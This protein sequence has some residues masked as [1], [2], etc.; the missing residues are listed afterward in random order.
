MSTT[1]PPLDPIAPTDSPNGVSEYPTFQPP[2]G[3]DRVLRSSDEHDFRVH[4]VL[5]VMVS[6]VFRKM[7][8]SEDMRG[9]VIKL[10]EDKE[11]LSILFQYIY[12]GGCP[13]LDNLTQIKKGLAAAGA[14]EVTGLTK[15]LDQQLRRCMKANPIAFE[16]L[17][18]WHLSITLGLKETQEAAARLVTVARHDFRRPQVLAELA[19]EHPEA[20]PLIQLVGSQGVRAK[21][22]ADILFVFNA[23]PMLFRRDTHPYTVFLM[24]PSCTRKIVT[25][26]SNIVPAWMIQWAHTTYTFLLSNPIEASDHLFEPGN[27]WNQAASYRCCI[28]VFMTDPTYRSYFIAWA[29]GVRSKLALQLREAE[30][31]YST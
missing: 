28:S 5:L 24:C 3:G 1:Q 27:M 11:A 22:L 6:S 23:P 30:S 25:L 21:A 31:V 13:A 20:A 14:Y 10:N 8:D 16:P 12:P 15:E 4:S 19:R 17:K 18:V 2:V 7:F 9:H 29:S 26:T